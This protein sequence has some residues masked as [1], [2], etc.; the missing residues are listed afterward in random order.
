MAKEAL[1]ELVSRGDWSVK[2]DADKAIA[3][4]WTLRAEE[5]ARVVHV[6]VLYARGKIEFQQRCLNDEAIIRLKKLAT[7]ALT[8]LEWPRRGSGDWVEFFNLGTWLDDWGKGA[9]AILSPQLEG[10]ETWAPPGLAAGCLT[11]VCHML[12][13]E[14]KGKGTG[15]WFHKASSF[16]PQTEA[17]LA[18]AAASLGGLCSSVRASDLT[19]TTKAAPLALRICLLPSLRLS[20]GSGPLPLHSTWGRWTL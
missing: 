5:G 4:S 9:A 17:L 16:P 13:E 7:R 19:Y 11:L 8:T 14:A 18:R 1:Q 15:R 2:E 10:I 20:P 6:R 12:V 3:L